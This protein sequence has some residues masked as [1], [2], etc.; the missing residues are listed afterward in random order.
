MYEMIFNEQAFSYLFLKINAN[1][2]SFT[3]HYVDIQ[4]INVLNF[5]P[6]PPFFRI[7]TIPIY[8]GEKS[9]ARNPALNYS[10]TRSFYTTTGG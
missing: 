3:Y 1:N 10:L 7:T 4:P 5:F 2:F 8:I 6:F 9:P